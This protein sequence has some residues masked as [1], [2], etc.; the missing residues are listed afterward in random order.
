M[1]R[2]IRV[3]LIACILSGCVTTAR[4]NTEL[5]EAEAQKTRA[6]AAE[7]ALADARSKLAQEESAVDA[8]K[9]KQQDLESK[10]RAED[11]QI[12][13]L[14]KSN[15]ELADSAAAKSPHKKPKKTASTAM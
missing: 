7:Q 12:T 4:F 11:D 14:Q 3:A 10:L 6:D 8:E 1:A 9:A 2:K 5:A 15:K 13:Q